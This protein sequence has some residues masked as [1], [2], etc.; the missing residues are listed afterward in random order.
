MNERPHFLR[1]CIEL[2]I[3]DRMQSLGF[4]LAAARRTSIQ[5]EIGAM[6]ARHLFAKAEREHV[7]ACE[8]LKL[9]LH[10]RLFE[11]VSCITSAPSDASPEA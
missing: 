4:Y 11:G 7:R 9:L 1:T 5:G 8:A 3:V 2:E 6:R 10:A